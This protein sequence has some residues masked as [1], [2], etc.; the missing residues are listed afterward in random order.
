MRRLTFAFAFA[1]SVL[2]PSLARAQAEPPP[3]LT[4]PSPAPEPAEHLA[5]TPI[6]WRADYESAREVLL[7]G[8]FDDAAK[9]FAAL[10]KT[11]TNRLDRAL[12]QAQRSLAEAWAARKLAFVPR[13]QIGESNLTAKAVDKRTTDEL[14]VLYTDA[15]LYGIGTGLWV[16]QLTEPKT[17]AGGILP[18]I[19]L[20]GASVGTVA[21]LDS[22]RGLRYGVAQGIAS[23]LAIGFESGIV[24][25]ILLENASPSSTT[26]KGTA[27]LIW[28]LSTA[29]A[30]TG[31]A[32]GATLGTTPGRSSWVGSTALWTGT[33]AGLATGALG[34]R[35]NEPTTPL[36]A[37]GVGLAA[38]TALG[39]ATASGVSPSIS[40]VRFLDLGGIGGGLLGG[41][42]YW[43]AADEKVDGRALSGTTALGAA[44]GLGVVWAL[45]SSMQQD[46]PLGPDEAAPKESWTAR[47]RPSVAPVDRGATFGLTGVLD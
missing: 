8:D 19:G 36:A 32:L 1:F 18:M 30:I 9:R 40:R 26:G 21:L 46:R 43:G 27:S 15:V 10:E 47:L 39:L 31:G 28:G 25:S 14:A 35:Q 38:G 44:A 37:A 45:T 29:G 23:G 13:A 24:W 16:A 3:P 22:G 5:P 2:L 6:D 33:L 4:E 17:A 42:L 34:E 7:A 12:A 41:L 11:A 20:T